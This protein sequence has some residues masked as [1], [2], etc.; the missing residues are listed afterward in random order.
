MQLRFLGAAGTV[1][2]SKTQVRC[3]HESILV[4]C[5]L[6]QGVK[7][8]RERNWTPLPLNVRQLKAVVLTHAH[9]DHSGYLPVLVRQGFRGPIYCSEGTADLCKILLPDAAHLQEEDAR[10]ANRHG[11]SKHRPALPLFTQEDVQHTLNLLKPYDFREKFRLLD[12]LHASFSRAGHIIGASCLHLD[13]GQ[14]HVVFS[15]DVGR[16]ADVIMR[17]PEPLG[18]TDILVLESTYGNRRHEA[19]DPEAL[20]T[21]L[22]Q[23]VAHQGGTLLIPA[24]AVGRAQMAL[25]LLCGLREAGRIPPIPIYLN[26]PMAI[27]ATEVFTQYSHEH[28]LTAHECQRLH[29]LVNYVETAEASQQLTARHGPMIVVSASGMATGGRV[30]HHLRQVLPD[31]NSA[32]L[33]MGFQAPGT[34]GDAIAHGHSPIAIHGEMIPVHCT[35]KHIDSLSAH[36]DYQELVQ[37]LGSIPHPPQMTYIN[38]G[39]PLAADA[40]RKTLKTQLGF[41]ARAVDYLDTFDTVAAVTAH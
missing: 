9:L 19:T 36:A 4:D 25:H 24:F 10:Y 30:L 5:G 28:H 38:H 37:W 20:L 7:N 3:N 39:E 29:Q 1:T 13:D 41:T 40:L 33:F 31:H 15:G 22:V 34:R 11:F 2:G 6:F 21:A 8:F 27:K 18:P 32:V 12:Q 17:D 35:V 14:Q 16:H 23:Q 26:S